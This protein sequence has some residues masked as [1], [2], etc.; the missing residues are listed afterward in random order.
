MQF[1]FVVA[2]VELEAMGQLVGGVR[3]AQ[4]TEAAQSVQS[5]PPR[6]AMGSSGS[7]SDK[8]QRPENFLAELRSPHRPL[9]VLGI[10]FAM[11]LLFR[12]GSPA[13]VVR[14]GPAGT[15]R[16]RCCH[17]GSGVGTAYAPTPFTSTHLA[18]PAHKLRGRTIARLHGQAQQGANPARSTCARS[19]RPGG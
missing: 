9:E 7:D 11:I 5:K 2:A 1:M 16:L 4:A 14:T 12:S 18:W 19:E 8:L 6:A 10:H 13:A 17:A 3:F 15:Q